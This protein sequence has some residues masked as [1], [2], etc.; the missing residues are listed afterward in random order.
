MSSTPAESQ[1]EGWYANQMIRCDSMRPR[2]SPCNCSSQS[3][4]EPVNLA[5]TR[6]GPQLAWST[7]CPIK[8]LG[9][10]LLTHCN[11]KQLYTAICDP[12]IAMQRSSHTLALTH[13][14][15]RPLLGGVR[16]CR[17]WKAHS[18][19]ASRQTAETHI[20]LSGS[21]VEKQVIE[22]VFRSRRPS[23]PEGCGMSMPLFASMSYI[24]SLRRSQ[25][26]LA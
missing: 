14:L 23:D 16:L 10:G 4:Y 20:E 2:R 24:R 5:I 6:T 18:Q 13:R 19:D 12:L 17:G 1:S 15:S 3:S 9:H 25:R 21:S 11:E 8:P 26:R 7:Q 22:S